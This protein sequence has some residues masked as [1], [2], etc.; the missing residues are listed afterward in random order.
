M[1]NPSEEPTKPVSDH[2]ECIVTALTAGTIFSIFDMVW[3]DKLRKRVK[4]DIKPI[5]PVSNRLGRAKPIFNL[6]FG[7]GLYYVF[8][9][10]GLSNTVDTLKGLAGI[11][12]KNHPV[13]IADHQSKEHQSD[14]RVS[15][16][17][18]KRNE[19]NI[20]TPSERQ[21]IREESED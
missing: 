20:E 15:S 1:T 8:V 6:V 18:L 7:A 9:C 11:E 12:V 13:Q 21:R 10:N 14:P 5:L 4:K 3:V 2:T 16:F 19:E 17:F